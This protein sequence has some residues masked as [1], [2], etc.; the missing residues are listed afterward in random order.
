MCG[1]LGLLD[2]TREQLDHLNIFDRAAEGA[3]VFCRQGA[4]G[5]LGGGGLCSVCPMRILH[6]KWSHLGTAGQETGEG[7]L[8]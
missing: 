2:V 6:P 4:K 1:I 3:T 7:W 5:T 8:T